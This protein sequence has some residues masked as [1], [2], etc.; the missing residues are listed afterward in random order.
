MGLWWNLINPL[1]GQY[2]SNHIVRIVYRLEFARNIA[3]LNI[4]RTICNADKDW[5]KLIKWTIWISPYCHELK[6]F[7]NISSSKKE[8][9]I[10]TYV[11]TMKGE[12][13]SN[14]IL[15]WSEFLIQYM[16]SLKG[17]QGSNYIASWSELTRNIEKNST[18]NNM[19]FL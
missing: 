10:Q 1:C 6:F 19:C 18:M 8:L 15:S 13:S 2:W 14:H 4:D 7:K 3:K 5:S 12:Y 9:S 17:Q 11:E 16:R